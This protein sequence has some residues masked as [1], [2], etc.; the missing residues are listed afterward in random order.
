MM[1]MGF[2]KKTRIISAFP[3]TGKTFFTTLRIMKSL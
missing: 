1:D 3:A 2:A